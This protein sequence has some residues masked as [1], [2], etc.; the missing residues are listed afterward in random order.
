[1]ASLGIVWRNCFFLKMT[2][3]LTF[4]LSHFHMRNWWKKSSDLPSSLGSQYAIHHLT[5]ISKISSFFPAILAKNSHPFNT[6][7]FCEGKPTVKKK[8]SAFPLFFTGRQLTGGPRFL[9]Q[10][11][12][13]FGRF[14]YRF[15]NGEAGTDVFDRVSDFWS[16]LLRSMDTSPVENLVWPWCHEEKLCFVC[17][18]YR[19]CKD[20]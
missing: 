11:R 16:T 15:P 13:K 4:I 6:T 12:Q 20:T 7:P 9:G 2:S 1:M 19:C 14:Y 8:N 18:F 3:I 5:L 10:E 17:F